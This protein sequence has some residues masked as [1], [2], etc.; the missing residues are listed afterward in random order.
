MCLDGGRPHNGSSRPFFGRAAP[1]DG[2]RR[3]H[4]L[5]GHE[6]SRRERDVPRRRSRLAPVQSQRSHQQPPGRAGEVWEACID[7]DYGGRCQVF[8]GFE[9]D[10][11]QRRGWND[12]IPRCAASAAAAAAACARRSAGRRSS[13]YDRVGYRG[14]SR[15]LTGPEASLGSFGRTVQSVR[16]MSGRWEVCEGTR[17]SGRC[18]TVNN[19]VTD[20]QPAGSQRHRLGASAVALPPFDTFRWLGGRGVWQ[21]RVHGPRVVLQGFEPVAADVPAEPRLHRRRGRGAGARHRRQHRDLLGRQ[22]RAAQ[23]AAVPRPRPPRDVHEHL[24]AGRPGGAGSPAK[25]QHCPRADRRRPG[26]R[27][28]SA[29]ASSTTPADRFPSSCDRARSRPT[30]SGCSARRV[31][32]GRTFTPKKIARTATARRRAQPQPLDAPLRAAIPNVVGKTISLSGDPLHRRSASSARAFDVEEFGHEPRTSGCRSSS[33]RTRPIRGTTSRSPARLKPGVTLEQA[34]AR[35]QRLGRGLPAEV[36][37]RARPNSGFSVEPL[38]RS[39]RQQRRGRRC[40]CWSAR[41]ASCC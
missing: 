29:P 33:I 40:S 3:H 9:P 32:Q 2:R 34:K 31:L 19:N 38:A 21:T 28:P 7:I 36:S 12:E 16:I 26:R 37:Q 18:V 24:A 13:C 8:S 30:S 11:H 22:R 39:A 20:R 35:L 25:F 10:L 15:S 1:S 14:R 6:L 27:R 5:R 4:G 23:A 41:S 17:W